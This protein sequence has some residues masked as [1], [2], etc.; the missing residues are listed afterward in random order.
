MQCIVN[1][2][3]KNIFGC[4]VNVVDKKENI[5]SEMRQE[6]KIPKYIKLFLH[7]LHYLRK[8]FTIVKR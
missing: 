8:L 6:I 3:L 1:Y 2:V 7:P 4:E 5:P